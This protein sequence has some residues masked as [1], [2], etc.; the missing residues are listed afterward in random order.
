MT[1]LTLDTGA[2]IALERRNRRMVTFYRLVQARRQSLTVPT[3]S[4]AEWWDD[5]N[6]RTRR[7]VLQGVTVEPL[8]ERI[9]KLAG[10]ARARVPGPSIADAIVMASAAQRGDIVIT[11]DFDD[12]DRLR[13]VFPSVRVLGL[14][15]LP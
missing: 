13:T 2:L 11:S 9:A 4:I 8:S 1:G 10:E 3:V 12:L 15:R 5:G 7:M 6:M 14:T